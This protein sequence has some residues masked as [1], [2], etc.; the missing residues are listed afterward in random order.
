MENHWN[1]ALI[2]AQVSKIQTRLGI[3]KSDFGAPSHACQYCS[4]V[5]CY[6]ESIKRSQSVVN[7]EFSICCSR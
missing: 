1:P 2:A 3:R 6:Q 7:C 5:D 4:V